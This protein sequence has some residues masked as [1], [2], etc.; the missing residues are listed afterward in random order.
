M[1]SRLRGSCRRIRRCRS[2]VSRE[3]TR[4]HP[5]GSARRAPDYAQVRRLIG[6]GHNQDTASPFRREDGLRRAP[7]CGEALTLPGCRSDRP[8]RGR[9]LPRGS[10]GG[11]AGHGLARSVRVDHALHEPALAIILPLELKPHDQS[12]AAPSS[13]SPS[14]TTPY[15]PRTVSVEVEKSSSRTAASA[16]SPCDATEARAAL[17]RSS[18]APNPAAAVLPG[19]PSCPSRLCRTKAAAVARRPDVVTKCRL[20]GAPP[21]SCRPESA[22]PGRGAGCRKPI[23]IHAN[24]TG[25]QAESVLRK[26]HGETRCLSFIQVDLRRSAPDPVHGSPGGSRTGAPDRLPG[27]GFR[28]TVS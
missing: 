6:E 4:R 7:G 17:A 11:G 12:L 19:L 10:R 23:P 14:G 27:E 9:Q 28:R 18:M 3:Q 16:I 8:W 2:L 25:N 15:G 1:G 24:S 26:S 21:S 5:G 22:A 13:R 20:S